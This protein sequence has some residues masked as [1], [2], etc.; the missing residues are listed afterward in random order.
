M[1]E[2]VKSRANRLSAIAIAVVLMVT[3]VA[4]M[5]AGAGF[6]RIDAGEI[7]VRFDATNGG[8]AA[9]LQPRFEFYWP[10]ER[11]ITYPSSLMTSQYL[12]NSPEGDRHGEDSVSAQTSSGTQVNLDV[13]IYWRVMPENISKVFSNFGEQ[14]TNQIR[15]KYLRPLTYVATNVVVGKMTVEEVLVLRRGELNDLIKDELV[16]M[17]TPL[18]I[19]IEDVNVGEIYPA[20]EVRAA[21]DEL[22]A[23]RNQLQLL[24]KQEQTAKEDAKRIITEAEQKAEQAKLLSALGDKAVLSKKLEIARI[25]AEKWNGSETV[26]GP[27]TSNR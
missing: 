5:S 9:V 7:G 23:T 12:R 14:E 4:L 2:T 18:G 17:A 26:V 19:T 11:L 15:D 3:L 25:R 1:S 21:I 27:K 24:A 8:Q 13:S 10:T 6:K 20:T 22:V 16:L